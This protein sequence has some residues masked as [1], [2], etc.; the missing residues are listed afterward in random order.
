MVRLIVLTE[1]QQKLLIHEPPIKNSNLLFWI[2]KS[3]NKGE[4]LEEKKG[5]G[6]HH[7]NKDISK[8]LGI[9]SQSIQRILP[10]LCVCVCVCVCVM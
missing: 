1:H 6:K 8:V 9:N 5:I 4:I 7:Q 3:F 10:T 2:G